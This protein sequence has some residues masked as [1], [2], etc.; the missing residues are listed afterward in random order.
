MNTRKFKRTNT[1]RSFKKKVMIK[2]DRIRRKCAKWSPE[3]NSGLVRQ[4][5]GIGE[6]NI[7]P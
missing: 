1:P 7:T 6:R 4:K 2:L 3:N 5:A